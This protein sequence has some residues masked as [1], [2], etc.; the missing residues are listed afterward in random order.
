MA[1]RAAA[2]IL[3]LTSMSLCF[4]QTQS[5]S[6][7]GIEGVITIGP[8]HPGPTREGMPSSAPLANAAFTVGNEKGTVTSSFTTDAHGRFRISLAAG[9]YTIAQRGKTGIRACGPFDVDVV[10]GKM[11]TVQWE[12]D[13]G[14][15]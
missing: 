14:M 13:T 6:A 7:T 4:G 3:L 10:S 12:C 15:R 5:E 1:K 2:I 11:T 8:I 9:R